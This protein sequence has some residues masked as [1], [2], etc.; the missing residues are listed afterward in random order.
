MA[1]IFDFLVTRLAPFLSFTT[2]EAWDMRP[3]GV[4]ED[5]E[6][7]HM[8]TY[9]SV[10]HE[11]RNVALEE[12]WQNILAVRNVVLAALEPERAQ[13]VIGSSLESHPHIY[14]SDAVAKSLNGADMAE[15]C[16][17]SQAT[18]TKGSAPDGAIRDSKIEGVAVVFQKSQGNKCARS[19]KILPEVGSDKEYPDLTL[20]DADAVRWY[21]KQQKAA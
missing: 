18:V 11:W 8:R 7:V 13:K 20:R 17:T 6:S 2:E 9:S 14:V 5:S 19:W 4:F 12:K 10:P 21:A 15:I 3:K 16:I 1:E